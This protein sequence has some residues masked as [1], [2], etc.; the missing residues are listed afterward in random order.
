MPLDVLKTQTSGKCSTPD[1]RSRSASRLSLQVKTSIIAGHGSARAAHRNTSMIADTIAALLHAGRSDKVALSAPNRP[2]LTYAGLREQLEQTVTAINLHGIGHNDR[3]AMVLPNGPELASAF[4]GIA[5]GA[6]AAPLNP[7][8]RRDEFNFYLS[9]LHAKALVVER[10]S[11]SPAV[12]AARALNIPV[13]ELIWNKNDPAGKFSIVGDRIGPPKLDGFARANDIGLLLH[14]SGTTSRPKLVPL[15]QR[16]LTSSASNIVHTLKLTGEDRC[17][18]I[19]PLFHIH[20]LIAGVLASLAAGGSVFCT[21]GFDVL[22]V[23]AWMAEAAPTWYTAVPAMHQAILA[24]ASQARA[25]QDRAAILDRIQLRFIRSSS[26]PLPPAV[27]QNLEQAFSAPVIESY[28]MT[29]A[30]HQMA[31]NPLPPAVRKPGKVGLAA[32]PEIAIMDAESRLLP[33]GAAGEVVIRGSNVTAGY[34]N[35]PDANA[36]AFTSGWFRTGDEGVLDEDGYLTI[37]GRLKEMINRG[38]EKVSPREVDDVLMAHPNVASAATFPI[39]HPTLGE[40]IAAAVVVERGV[41]LTEQ[42]LAGFL[43]SRLADFKIPRRFVFVDEVPKSP[44]G[45]VQRH[46][47]AEKLGL[48]GGV[49][50]LRASRDMSEQPTSLEAKLTGLWGKTLGLVDKIGLH[51]NFFLLGGDSLQA[52]ELLASIE[53]TLGFS[54]PQ[55]VLIE[56]GTIAEMAAYIE[57][58]GP[59]SCVV[60]IQPK[61]TRPR[62][63]CVHH[64]Q[65]EVLVFRNLARHLGNDQPFYGIQAVGLDYRQKPHTRI[66]DMATHYLREIRK[67]QPAGP[68][69][70]GGYSMGGIVAYEMTQQLKAEGEQVALLALLD[71]YSGP[72][73]RRVILSQY[74]R[75]HWSRL[76]KLRFAEMV[77]YLA[78]RL[79]ARALVGVRRGLLKGKWLLFNLG[80]KRIPKVEGL[81]SVA[82]THAMATQAYRMRPCD[83]DAVLFTGEL[84]T[85]DDRGMHE[86]WKEFILGDLEIRPIRGAHDDIVDEPHVRVL[87]AELSDCLERRY[88]CRSA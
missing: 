39:P 81:L 64:L 15:S 47:L 80:N 61:G 74:L 83:C 75:H 21:P 29:E 71:T 53:K 19:M 28:G 26:A 40:E 51:G 67:V 48:S 17:F 43:S 18:N 88:A 5:A 41:T 36:T 73:R 38:G 25:D 66:E 77:D 70:L 72:R 1:S 6:S 68:Y 50:L 37:T 60:P 22:E 76:S 79:R 44:T 59:F 49:E 52:V 82:E 84:G 14:T 11:E 2:S 58:K 35:N 56:H 42:A 55:S 12:V 85:W 3:V 32:G 8:Y 33:A 9:D 4:L 65:G 63:F 7:A 16:N 24:R 13:V 54:L 10:N 34:E 31:S 86:G 45:K 46:H 78:Y 62:F 20:G 23:L 57:K 87:A 27:M 30:A 69:Y